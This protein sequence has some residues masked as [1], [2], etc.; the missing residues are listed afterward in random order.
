MLLK[1]APE[2]LDLIL[3]LGQFNFFSKQF[4]SLELRHGHHSRPSPVKLV[5]LLRILV[6]NF[7]LEIFNFFLELY[8]PQ[9]ILILDGP[10][11][12]L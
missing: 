9:L 3:L 8:K 10:N 1:L 7:S 12:R 5:K 11:L 2:L 6:T 4:I